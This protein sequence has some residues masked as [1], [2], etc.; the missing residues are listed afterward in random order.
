MSSSGQIG[1]IPNKILN[2]FSFK[3]FQIEQASY[4]TRST[5]RGVFKLQKKKKKKKRSIVKFLS[6]SITF[7]SRALDGQV[8]MELCVNL[9]WLYWFCKTLSW[10]LNSS[11]LW[12]HFERWTCFSM[13]SLLFWAHCPFSRENKELSQQGQ[14][15]SRKE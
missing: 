9:I 11:R 6:F 15:T 4:K 10:W 5:S 7:L 2:L 13:W 3:D 12:I 8:T 14:E 1:K